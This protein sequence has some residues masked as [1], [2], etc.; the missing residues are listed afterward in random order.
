VTL[1]AVLWDNDGVLVE[2]ESLYFQATRE[3]LDSAGIELPRDVFIELSLRQG[4]SCFVLAERAGV[5]PGEIEALRQARDRRYAELLRAGV[6]LQPGVAPCLAALHGRVRMAVV[7]SSSADHFE[8]IHARTALRGYFEFVLTG[9]ET[10]RHKPHPDPY[11]MAAARLGVDPAE[12]LAIEDT[13]RGL[14]SAVAAGMRCAVIPHALTSGGDFSAAWRV[15]EHALQVPDLVGPLG[16][17]PAP[18]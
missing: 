18:G 14:A 11:R 5:P 6:A 2:T 12:C 8:L 3:L 17:E 4:V 15:L 16:A 10:P 7:T 1:R 13:E 9:E